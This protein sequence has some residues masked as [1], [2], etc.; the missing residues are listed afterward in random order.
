MR[1]RAYNFLILVLVVLFPILSHATFDEVFFG[2][3]VIDG[4][5]LRISFQNR[6]EGI[7][8]FEI[9]D[10]RIADEKVFMD[11]KGYGPFTVTAELTN[12]ETLVIY[13]TPRM[14]SKAKKVRSMSG[15]LVRFTAAGDE[16]RVRFVE[17]V[18]IRFL[19]ES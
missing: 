17:A 16:P 5:N 1:R 11:T 19:P 18:R 4:Q 14:D 9:A 10:E 3:Y 7:T 12:G 6:M 8:A 2:R 15:Y 13:V